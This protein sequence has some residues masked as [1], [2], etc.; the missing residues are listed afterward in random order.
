HSV[1]VALGGGAVGDLAGFAA[2]TLFRGVR[3]VCVPTS[4]LAM[5]DSSVGGKTGINQGGAKNQLGAFHQPVGVFCDLDLLATLPER[6]YVSGLAEVV[7]TA[8][9]GDATLLEV[10]EK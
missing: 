2:A 3:W 1:I 10:L 4:L 6:E 5:V 8:A 7:K 9:I